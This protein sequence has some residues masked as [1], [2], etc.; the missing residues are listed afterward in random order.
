MRF[1]LSCPTLRARIAQQCA[2]P[3]PDYGPLRLYQTV[4]KLDFVQ[5]RPRSEISFVAIWSQAGSREN[6]IPPKSRHLATDCHIG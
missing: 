1:D 6:V 2:F 4:Y 3:F 5:N